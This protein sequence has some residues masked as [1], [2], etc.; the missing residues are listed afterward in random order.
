M[1]EV[2]D[3]KAARE[4]RENDAAKHPIL[5]ALD[6]LALALVEHG[7]TWTDREYDLYETAVGYILNE[8]GGRS[9]NA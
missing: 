7:H 4:R 5:E 2:I 6:S 3:L 1:A 8:N 9:P